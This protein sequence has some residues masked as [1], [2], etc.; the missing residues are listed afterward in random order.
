MP[1]AG[2]LA[3]GLRSPR[4]RRDRDRTRRLT[5]GVGQ[6]EQ[7]IGGRATGSR[8]GGEPEHR[9]TVLSEAERKSYVMICCARANSD[10]LE[11]DL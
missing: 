11:L 3:A 8:V 7:V 10:V 9:E 2:H 6:G 4:R 1:L 5:D